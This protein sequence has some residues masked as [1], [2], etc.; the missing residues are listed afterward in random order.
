MC[1]RYSN[2]LLKKMRPDLTWKWKGLSLMN[3]RG[4]RMSFSSFIRTI[5][6]IFASLCR[7]NWQL[8]TLRSH[9]ST[10]CFWSF[11]HMHLIHLS[12][13]WIL[14]SG[15]FTNAIA[16]SNRFFSQDRS[17]QGREHSHN[18]VFFFLLFSTAFI[19][20]QSLLKRLEAGKCLHNLPD[21]WACGKCIPF[22]LCLNMWALLGP[23][24]PCS[25]TQG[26][27]TWGRIICRNHST[28]W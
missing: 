6:G 8:L 18:H 14:F 10:R 11:F 24:K 15:V 9:L 13:S 20:I 28:E 5:S 16:L 21:C 17:G 19:T 2:A 7:I 26:C 27:D 25:A 23:N 3:F 4:I 1:F 12:S 22:S